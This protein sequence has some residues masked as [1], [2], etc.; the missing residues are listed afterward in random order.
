[1]KG[2][3]DDKL[4]KIKTNQI[5]KETNHNQRMQIC[6]TE[7]AEKIVAVKQWKEHNRN[8][9]N[10]FQT[11]TDI[12]DYLVPLVTHSDIIRNKENAIEKKRQKDNEIEMKKSKISSQALANYNN[13]YNNQSNQTYIIPKSRY[14]INEYLL[15]DSKK[16]INFF[17][18][19]FPKRLTLEGNTNCNSDKT[20][21]DKEKQNETNF[22]SVYKKLSSVAVE[23]NKAKKEIYNQKYI[24]TEK[25]S[26]TYVIIYNLFNAIFI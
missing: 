6:D 12:Q 18:E 24:D 2:V 13:Y 14:P 19:T 26:G 21:K 9:Y 17:S 20:N 16:N 15:E 23:N 25:H 7:I 3:Y 11:E 1:M 22:L 8:K 5:D 10:L 4:N